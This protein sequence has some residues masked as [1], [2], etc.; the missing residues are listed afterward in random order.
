MR[1]PLTSRRKQ[2]IQSYLRGEGIIV[3]NPFE[4]RDYSFPR[5]THDG[6]CIFF[7]LTAKKCR[8]HPV[9]PETCVAGP[10]TFDINRETGKIE[11]F[12]KSEK[13]CLLA[14]ALYRDKESFDRHWK[15]A[16]GEILTL[17]QNL[18]SRALC[19]ILAISEPDTYKFNEEYLNPEVV[20]KLKR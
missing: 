11:W 13:I 6:Y 3:R 10:I 20:A 2:A 9:K 19:A 8:I 4:N 15:S 12:V 1:P 5:E 18:D 14:A 17:V 16:K 7:D